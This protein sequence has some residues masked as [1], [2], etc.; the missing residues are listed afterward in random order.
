MQLVEC[1]PNF[2]EGRR[3]EVI[4]AIVEAMRGG[5]ARLLDVRSDPDHNRFQVSMVGEPEEVYASAMAGM[6]KA[7]ELIDM[8]AHKGEH[9]RIGAADVVPFVPVSDY[10][11]SDCVRLA[12][13]FGEEASSRFGVPVYL[14]EAAAA[15]PERRDLAYVRRGQYEGLKTSIASD[16]DRAPDFGPSRMGKAG[17]TAVGAREFLIAFNVYLETGDVEV[18]KR[19]A[20]VVRER[21]GGLPFVKALG[22]ETRPNVQVSMNLTNFRATPVHA[23]LAKVEQEA[24]RLGVGIGETEIFGMVPE[25]AMLDAAEHQLLLKGKWSRDLIIERRI[26][27][28]STEE[29]ALG[30]MRLDRFLRELASDSP[31]PGGGS[32]SCLMGA[33]GAALGAMVCRLSIGKKGMEDLAPMFERKAADLDALRSHL[34][35]AMDDDA[36]AFERVMAAFKL[37]KGT[38]EEK[39]GR[40]EAIQSAYKGAI[41]VPLATAAKCRQVIETLVEVG[42]RSNPNARSDISVGIRAARAGLEGAAENVLINLQAI[43]DE[44]YVLEARGRLEVAR[45]GIDAIASSTIH[46]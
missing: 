31:A 27:A 2:S 14:Y 40:S 10:T 15:R 21:D 3:K 45:N 35:R 34:V 36:E 18:A 22:M 25:D 30:K 33:I 16:P 23:V 13:R 6:G 38:E 1:V 26:A 42:P 12:R 41:E 9:P 28:M 7:V 20:K 32:A 19:I 5:G 46:W 43:K 11:L 29:R 8:D 24:S 17:A 39:R 4:E 44:A 37:P